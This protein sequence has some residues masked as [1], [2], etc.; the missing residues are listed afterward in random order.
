MK[1]QNLFD[2]IVEAS[3]AKNIGIKNEFNKILNDKGL[4]SNE[5]DL[6]KL[7]EVMVEYLQDSLP[8]IKKNLS[9]DFE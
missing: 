4:T 7:R 3:N 6:P 5:L 2:F 1:G 9:S 8:K